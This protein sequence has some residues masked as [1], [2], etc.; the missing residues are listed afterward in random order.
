M[1]K[2]RMKTAL[3]TGANR[4]IGLAITAGLN[5]LEEMKVLVGSRRADDGHNAART[6]GGNAVGVQLDLST[7]D[8]LEG[9]IKTVVDT[10]GPIDILV[11]NAGVLENGNILEI[12]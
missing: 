3:V 2:T 10:H 9:Q 4:G 7:A 6:L 5:R 1:Q 12:D 11:N 8:G